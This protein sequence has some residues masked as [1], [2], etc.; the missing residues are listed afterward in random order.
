MPTTTTTTAQPCLQSGSVSLVV[1]GTSCTS[2]NLN[3][4]F[5]LTWSS[6]KKLFQYSSGGRL[7][8]L[9][10]CSSVSL[11]GN[12]YTNVWWLRTGNSGGTE[13]IDW[14]RD[15]QSGQQCRA[16]DYRIVNTSSCQNQGSASVS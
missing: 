8:T 5:T 11:G 12:S 9:K 1:S 10:W 16:S 4:T 15:D 14:V 3:G 7:H 13:V 6:L 2:V